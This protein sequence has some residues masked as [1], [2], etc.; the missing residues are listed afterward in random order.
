MKLVALRV[1]AA[2]VL[3]VVVVDGFLEGLDVRL[4]GQLDNVSVVHIDA[5]L[6]VLRKL[7]EPVVQVLAMR[8]VLLKAEDSPLLEVDRLLD[9]G[10]EDLG[11]VQRLGSWVLRI[12]HS[13][14]A[15]GDGL[16]DL[17]SLE[18]SGFDAVRL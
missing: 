16:V 5:K 6:T 15:L 17:R 8:H 13:L 10:A 1:L 18:D 11:V 14:A 12:G 9:D 7:V 3:Q 2:D 4:V